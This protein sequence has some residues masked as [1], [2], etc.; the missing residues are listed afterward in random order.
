MRVGVCF[1]RDRRIIR[2]IFFFIAL[3]VGGFDLTGLGINQAHGAS[4]TGSSGTGSSGKAS[5]L[6]ELHLGWPLGAPMTCLGIEDEIH[7]RIA[8]V[9]EKLHQYCN[10]HSAV[11]A[12]NG[13]PVCPKD[14]C[15]LKSVVGN[16]Q[17]NDDQISIKLGR[18]P[19]SGAIILSVS[20]IYVT[21]GSKEPSGLTCYD[22]GDYISE[23]FHAE[24]D[25]WSYV[26][27]AEF[28]AGL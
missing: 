8:S 19:W 12:A 3:M 11:Q 2:F 22:P 23:L 9:S 14:F 28:C 15:P 20:Y 27:L 16:Q 26:K 6:G 21:V 24:V 17:S 4:L 1:G 10:E 25:S 7:H 18:D 13:Y 5:D